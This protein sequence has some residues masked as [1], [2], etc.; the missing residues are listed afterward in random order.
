MHFVCYT[1]SM[2][3]LKDIAMIQSGYTFR[4]RIQDMP[5]GGVCVIQ[6]KDVNAGDLSDLP[7]I[8]FTNESQLLRDGD[9]LLSIRGSFKALC[10]HTHNQKMVAASSVMVLR[11][12]D[13]GISPDY[14][15]MYFNSLLGQELLRSV[16]TGATISALTKS[17]LSTVTI[18]VPPPDKQ[19]LMTS[20]Q[21]NINQQQQLTQQKIKLTD[22][23]LNQI[24]TTE[25]RGTAL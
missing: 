8:S 6:A 10:V 11:L 20:L 5:D 12:K 24:I 18:P 23:L 16:A 4:E 14:L 15:A 1:G 7:T 2:K 17:I 3:S 22:T 25:T 9:V 13:S 21:Q 19:R